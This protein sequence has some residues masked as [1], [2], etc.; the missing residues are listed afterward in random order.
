MTGFT[1]LSSGSVDEEQA[2]EGGDVSVKD[3]SGED[4]AEEE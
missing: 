2:E 4:E 1:A 3:T